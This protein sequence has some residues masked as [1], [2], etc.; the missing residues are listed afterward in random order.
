MY[1]FFVNFFILELKENVFKQIGYFRL[2]TIFILFRIYCDKKYHAMYIHA[3][4]C[5]DTYPTSNKKHTYIFLMRYV[6][7]TKD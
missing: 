6:F 2:K 5:M 1:N 4:V 7:N 3:Y